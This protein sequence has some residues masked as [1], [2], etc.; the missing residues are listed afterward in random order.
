M[1]ALKSWKDEK[2]LLKHL[3]QNRLQSSDGTNLKRA[4]VAM[5]E[6]WSP[7]LRKGLEFLCE[8]SETSPTDL[9]SKLFVSFG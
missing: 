3:A 6:T 8:A 9:L 1:S 7:S 4:A 2:Y 5:L